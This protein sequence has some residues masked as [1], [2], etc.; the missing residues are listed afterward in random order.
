MT[1]EDTA[2]GYNFKELGILSDS[3]IR[4]YYRL[5]PDGH[6]YKNSE[7]KN[8]AD[9]CKIKKNNNKKVLHRAISYYNR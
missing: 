1:V 3:E 6:L 4:K 2:T 7:R 8:H 5:Q 9:C